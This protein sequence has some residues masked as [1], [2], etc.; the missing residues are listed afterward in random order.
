MDIKQESFGGLGTAGMGEGGDWPGGS[1]GSYLFWGV[2]P[3][4]HLGLE[5]A[6]PCLLSGLLA[7]PLCGLALTW[8][9]VWR[10][11]EGKELSLEIRGIYKKEKERTVHAE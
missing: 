9:K 11:W 4:P 8:C 7:P 1:P 3:L 2:S 10:V 5:R 6:R